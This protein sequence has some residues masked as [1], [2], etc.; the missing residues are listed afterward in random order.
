M[1]YETLGER[2]AIDLTCWQLFACPL[3][4]RLGNLAAAGHGR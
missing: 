1:A 3:V 4:R 2:I